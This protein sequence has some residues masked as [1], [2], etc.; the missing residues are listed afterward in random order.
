M[1]FQLI[2]FC[3]VISSL[4]IAQ[5]NDTQTKDVQIFPSDLS[6]QNQDSIPVEKK[7]L[8]EEKKD[9]LIINLSRKKRFIPYFKSIDEVSIK[10]YKLL[11]L[12]GSEK[13]VD[14]SLSLEREYSFNFLRKDY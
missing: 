12:D 6:L 11:F 13:T 1:R 7:N 5:Q 2:I 8:T 9:S 4:L 14:T 3:L 10:D